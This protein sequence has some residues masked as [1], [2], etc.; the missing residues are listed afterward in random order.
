MARKK[1]S[2]T[3]PGEYTEQATREVAAEL[4]SAF[5]DFTMEKYGMLNPPSPYIT[6]TGIKPLDA[7]LGGG[8]SSSMPVAFSSTP[9]TR[10]TG[11]YK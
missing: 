5:D 9:E 1:V 3:A 8:L 2:K 6:P 11:L 7:L 4:A 10:I